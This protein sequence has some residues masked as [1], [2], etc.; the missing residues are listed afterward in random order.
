MPITKDGLLTVYKEMKRVLDANG[1]RFYAMYGTALGAVRDNGIIPWDND[2]DIGIFESDMDRVK[3]IMKTQLSD[4]FYFHVPSADTHCHVFKV[5]EDFEEDLRNKEA[6]FI[7]IFVIERFPS[8]RLKALLS[9]A[10]IRTYM[11]SMSLVYIPDSGFGQR[12]VRWIPK[13]IK[14][15]VKLLAGK[16]ADMTVLYEAEYR[17]TIL[18]SSTYGEPVQHVFEDS[19]I[20]LPEQ[21]G[22]LLT[23][24]YGD[25]MTPPP[26]DKRKGAEG[27]PHRAYQDYM[28]DSIADQHSP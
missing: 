28:R 14:K 25:Y 21:W 22:A 4:G 13:A 1:I 2:I 27:Y 16:G 11:L 8:G 26:E 5:T 23:E 7:D 3:E 18:P 17:R 19:V 9:R 20:Y 12:L 6:P 10:G 15:I 24:M